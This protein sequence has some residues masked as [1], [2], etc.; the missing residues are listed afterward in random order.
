MVFLPKAHLLLLLFSRSVVSD[1]LWSPWTAARQASLSFTISQNFLK[2]QNSWNEVKVAQSCLI[3]STPW[4]I[5]SMEFF[6]WI[7]LIQESNWGLLH[8]R[9]FL[10]QLRYQ[11]SQY[12][13]SLIMEKT[14]NTWC[15]D[16]TPRHISRQNSN[17]RRY[18]HSNIHSST[19]YC[20]QDMEAT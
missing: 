13:S 6:R 20:S 16:P 14:P 9:W 5:Q 12:S 10:Y 17:L 2:L 3:L 19:V 15:N 4:T 7:F 11:G 1:S 18:M 8:C